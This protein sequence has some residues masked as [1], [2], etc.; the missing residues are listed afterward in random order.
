VLAAAGLGLSADCRPL[1]FACSPARN[2]ADEE[3]PIVSV[4][5]L[6]Q[7]QSYLLELEKRRGRRADVI[8]VHWTTKLIDRPRKLGDDHW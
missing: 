6:E 8:S 2:T 1:G 3:S 7:R 5:T 4:L